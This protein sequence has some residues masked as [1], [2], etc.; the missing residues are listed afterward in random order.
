M[1]LFA[2]CI[3][4][5]S[6]RVHIY[7]CNCH[8]FLLSWPFNHCTMSLYV[9]H[10]AFNL[11]YVW[12]KILILFL[13]CFIFNWKTI[14][15]NTVLVSTIYQYESAIG[16]YWSP[17]SWP[18]FPLHPMPLG[19]HRALGLSSVH[20]K[21]NSHWLSILHMVMY[22]LQCHSQFAPP[23]PSPT[24]STSLF[25]VSSSPLRPCK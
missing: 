16:I 17:P 19:C 1:S 15:Y 24:V 13:N 20:H 9:S 6:Y 18:S 14:G 10:D 11:V 5:L 25:S 3:Y 7:I 2:L 12:V 8:V 21:T 4:L 23:S 22:M